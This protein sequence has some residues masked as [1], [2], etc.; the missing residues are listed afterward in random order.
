MAEQMISIDGEMYKIEIVDDNI[1]NIEQESFKDTETFE[2]QEELSP[3][4]TTV[5]FG[6]HIPESSLREALMKIS[7]KMLGSDLEITRVEDSNM[8][9]GAVYIEWEQESARGLYDTP[10]EENKYIVEAGDEI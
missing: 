4:A 7:E 8:S 9:D 1:E 5:P 2:L 10:D 6:A 3:V